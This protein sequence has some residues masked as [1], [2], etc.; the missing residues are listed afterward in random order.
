M[1]E[2][3]KPQGKGDGEAAKPISVSDGRER[4]IDCPH[5]RRSFEVLK[6][7]AGRET[8]CPRCKKPVQV[9]GDPAAA[10]AAPEETVAKAPPQTARPPGAAPATREPGPRPQPAG[11]APSPVI[12]RPPPKAAVRKKPAVPVLIGILA[13]SAA[14]IAVLVAQLRPDDEPTKSSL[15]VAGPEPPAEVAAVPAAAPEPP[16]AVAAVVPAAPDE[17]LAR[18]LAM[19]RGKLDADRPL[20][21]IGDPVSLTGKGGTGYSGIVMDVGVE[22]VSLDTANGV[23]MVPLSE[24]SRSS[25]ARLEPKMREDMIQVL[26]RKYLERNPGGPGGGTG[27]GPVGP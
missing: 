10:T 8:I 25:R 26:A 19:V 1:V 9:P 13:V 4:G 5:C 24:L 18:A 23:V 7:L 27:A 6:V 21:E 15:P 16:A 3:V 2:F 14:L 11:Q 22:T 20:A 12:K 17:P